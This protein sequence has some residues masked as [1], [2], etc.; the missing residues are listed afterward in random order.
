M[1]K[2]G[3]QWRDLPD[4]FGKWDTAYHRFNEWCMRGVWQRVLAA[5]RDPDLEWLLLDS[6]VVRAHPHAAGAQK[7]RV[8]RPSAGAAG[9]TGRRSTCA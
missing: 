7:K 8:P 3:I 5:V 9:G 6:T 4:R 2:T 1:A